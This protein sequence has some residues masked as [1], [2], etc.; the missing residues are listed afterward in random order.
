MNTHYVEE[1]N[2]NKNY[3]N[4]KKIINSAY[5]T[6]YYSDILK[7]CGIIQ[8]KDFS[9]REFN[10]IPIMNKLVYRDNVL[11]MISR[12]YY[13]FDKEYYKC[14]NNLSEKRSYLESKGLVYKI[15]SGSTGIPLEI[16][17]SVKD[18]NLDYLS[19]QY[20]RRKITN[21]N[22]K[23][24]YL[25]IWPVNPQTREILY[26]NDKCEKIIEINKYG[27]QYMLYEHSEENFYY[28]YNFIVKYK[29]EWLTISPSVIVSF[30]NF[31][32]NNNLHLCGIK[33]IECHSEKL[34]NWQRILIN[35]YFKCDISSIYSSNEV[36]FMAS[37]CCDESFHVF[38][39]SCFIEIEKRDRGNE[40][41]VTSLL[42]KDIPIIRYRLGDCA[43]WKT[44][45]KCSCKLSEL[46]KI[47]LSGVR[48]NDFFM[49]QDG[50]CIEPFVIT[51]S[52]IFLNNMLGININKYKVC[53]VKINLIRYY[54]SEEIEK[55][56]KIRNFLYSYYNKIFSYQIFIDIV[57]NVN[58]DIFVKDSNK[59]KYIECLI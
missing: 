19:L 43:E 14:I 15:T 21:Y 6:K 57:D 53:Q 34:H 39:K 55:K 52:I 28:I 3:F 48:T 46:P 26:P 2:F 23:G 30:V 9:Y 11:D 38:S 33:Y 36:Q 35:D 4:I 49:T 29:I 56:E 51:D 25:W 10:N 7:K 18:M 8:G 22:F 59:F 16:I 45:L 41:I 17:K 31:L 1:W 20:Y 24:K 44:S 12:E 5:N 42:S 58:F 50:K 32:N 27:F 40:I 13:D 47:K 37:E 54:F